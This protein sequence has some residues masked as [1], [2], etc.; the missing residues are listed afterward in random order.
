MTTVAQ[1]PVPPPLVHK[2]SVEE[3]IVTFWVVAEVHPP[4]VMVYVMMCDPVPAVEGLKVD[5]VTPVP[6]NV[7][8][9][10]AGVKVTAGLVGQ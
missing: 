9:A 2:G 4:L 8:P 1:V 3:S 10:V 7:P 6:E 5:P